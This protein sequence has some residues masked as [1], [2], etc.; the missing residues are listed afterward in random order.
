MADQ[1]HSNY[2]PSTVPTSTMSIVALVAG[3]LGLTIFPLLGSIVA[4]ITGP[5]AKKEII[6]SRGTLGGENLAQIGIILG[7][8]GL[9]LGLMGC[10]IALIAFAFPFVMLMFGLGSGDFG[11]VLPTLLIF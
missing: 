8:I 1:Y 5:M 4:I 10:C 2:N 6:E 11:L 7:W 3:I 9:A